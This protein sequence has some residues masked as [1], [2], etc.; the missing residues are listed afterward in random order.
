MWAE[1]YLCPGGLEEIAH[2]GCNKESQGE[3]N[4]KL[5]M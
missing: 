2:G 4:A 1:F 3:H 5:E